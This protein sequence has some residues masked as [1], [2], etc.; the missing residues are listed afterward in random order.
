[1]PALMQRDHEDIDRA[2]A[3]MVDP[4]TGPNETLWLLECARLAM[5]VHSAA[6]LKVMDSLVRRR[7]LPPIIELLA[8]QSRKEHAA[9][10]AAVDDLASVRP[11]SIRWYDKAFEVRVSAAEHASRADHLRWTLLDHVPAD[12]RVAIA[13]EY[14]TERLLVLTSTSPHTVARRREERASNE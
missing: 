12:I 8:M 13:S 3:A 10:R 7:D 9:Q 2:F 4:V 14:A 5:A 11:G 6:E 1:M